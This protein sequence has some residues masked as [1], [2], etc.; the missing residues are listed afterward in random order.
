MSLLGA[1]IIGPNAEEA[2][3]I[4]GLAIRLD[5]TTEQLRHFVA[6][7]PAAGSDIGYMLS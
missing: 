6:A 2:I 5:L 7:Y 4:F 3:N 1:R